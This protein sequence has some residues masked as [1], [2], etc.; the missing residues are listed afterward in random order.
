MQAEEQA[1]ALDPNGRRYL[2]A[3]SG[4]IEDS[5]DTTSEEATWALHSQSKIVCL[6]TVISQC[7]NELILWSDI[8]R[9]KLSYWVED[10]QITEL[11]ETLARNHF[12][13]ENRNPTNT[14]IYYFAL[15]KP[16]TVWGLWRQVA[17]H[18]ERAV[19]VKF[20][21][22]NF[23][24]PRWQSAAVKNAYALLG[25]QR[26]QYAAAFF[27][28]GE[29]PK[30]A[31]RIC[32]KHL[33]DYDLA[34]FI[35]RIRHDREVLLPWVIETYIAPRAMELND[36][37]LMHWCSWVQGKKEQAIMDVYTANVPAETSSDISDNVEKHRD[38]AITMA[39]LLSDLKS[40]EALALSVIKEWHFDPLASARARKKAKPSLNHREESLDP[41]QDN[42]SPYENRPIPKER[43]EAASVMAQGPVQ[44]SAQTQGGMEFDMGAFF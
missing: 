1:Q 20:L 9:H 6:Q 39:V 42:N 8:R 14:S 30:D 19:M 13:T 24:D 25:K 33:Q 4:H 41:S 17:G 43:S 26:F 29:C 40:C 34:I 37:W 15:R 5:S 44:D 21:Q 27:L 3:F 35:A 18:P 36:R 23:E 31:I 7:P 10:E 28:L 22:N 11:A 2:L 16:K 12:V 38:D 32:I